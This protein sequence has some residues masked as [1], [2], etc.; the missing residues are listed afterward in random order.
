MPGSEPPRYPWPARIEIHAQNEERSAKT[1]ETARELAK[2]KFQYIQP[3]GYTVN[4]TLVSTIES[5]M[6]G[7]SMMLLAKRY[8]LDST[9][10]WQS[11]QEPGLEQ[12]TSSC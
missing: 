3:N 4:V 7:S 1:L 10:H 2:N 8:C 6:T 12:R 9:V 5:L 11:S